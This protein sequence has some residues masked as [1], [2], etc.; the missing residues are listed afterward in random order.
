MECRLATHALVGVRLA[1]QTLT[2]TQVA[3]HLAF[4]TW[5]VAEHLE[6]ALCCSEIAVEFLDTLT[7]IEKLEAR[8]APAT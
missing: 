2:H 3:E 6:G 4:L 8:A 7:H 5:Q 1:T